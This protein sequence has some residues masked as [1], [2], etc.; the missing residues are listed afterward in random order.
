MY[1]R[2][3]ISTVM[4]LLNTGTLLAQEES[5]KVTFDAQVRVRSEFDGRD[6][7]AQTDLNTF[8]LLRARLGAHVVAKEDVEVYIQVQDSRAFGSAPH[9]LANTQNLDLHQGY[10]MVRNLWQKPIH[11]KVGRQE[12]KYGNERLL[13]AVGFSNVGRSFD[14]FL[15]RFGNR[16]NL[17]LFGAILRESS[18]PFSGSENDDSQLLGAYYQYRNKPGYTLDL[19][20]LFELDN[21]ETVAGEA[22]LRR[23]TLGTYNK[24]R[25]G[26]YFDFETELALQLGKRRGQNVKAFMLTGSVGYTFPIGR[27]PALRVG[28]DFLSGMDANDTDYKVFDTLFATN[29]KFY[30]FMDY[31]VNIPKNTNGQG[32]RDLMV[33]GTLPLANRLKALAHFHNFRAPK[34]AV[35]DFGNELDLVLRYKYNR[36]ASFEFVLAFFDPGE[37]MKQRF[38]NDDLAVWWYLSF[39]ATL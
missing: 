17:D 11:F 20:S 36:A 6:F 25:L 27:R 39:L 32:L 26:R 18:A 9:T 1:Q 7:N 33:K 4:L 35:K 28:M 12:L 22:D 3:L 30:G 21:A 8:S 2:I 31:F 23:L 5:T 29:H 13:G 15:L 14:A 37:L 10:L 24:G 19:Y 16:S 38:G 34:G